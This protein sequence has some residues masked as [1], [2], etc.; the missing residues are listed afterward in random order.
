VNHGTESGG[1]SYVPGSWAALVSTGSAMLLDVPQGSPLVGQLWAVISSGD[2]DDLVLQ[3]LIVGLVSVPSFGVVLEREGAV[4]VLVRGAAV[5]AVHLP[6]GVVE[7]SGAD[8]LTWS[9]QRFFDASPTYSIQAAAG[10]NELPVFPAGLGVVL[11]SR[12]NR[13]PALAVPPAPAPVTRTPPTDVQRPAPPTE[14]P[15][16]ANASE[17]PDDTIQFVDSGSESATPDKQPVAEAPIV[18][19]EVEARRSRYAQMLR[20][21]DAVPEGSAEPVVAATPEPEPPVYRY[22]EPEPLPVVVV[23]RVTETPIRAS[24]LI[25]SVP[26][27]FNATPATTPPQPQPQARTTSPSYP[28]E[29]DE[30]DIGVTTRSQNAQQLFEQSLAAAT[31]GPLV[32]AVRCPRGHLNSPQ[33]AICRE[34]GVPLAEQDPVRV[35]RPVLGVLRLSSGDTVSLDRDVILGRSPQPTTQ[36]GGSRPHL[37]R[38]TGANDVSRNHVSVELDGFLVLVRDLD[39]TNGTLVEIPGEEP[40]RLRVGDAVPVPPGT[41]I[42]LADAVWFRYELG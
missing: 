26:W 24:G 28:A 23:P 14:R 38:L 42:T 15:P 29:D 37:V 4:H 39:S 3:E 9:E 33:S 11:A 1:S 27:E 20:S 19:P 21:S 25:D 35:P 22:A 16:A 10:G 17:R 36:E 18:Q 31:A 6:E 34:C 32:H 41:L 8:L 12:L 2:S 30:D 7:V 13:G 5:V 40:Q